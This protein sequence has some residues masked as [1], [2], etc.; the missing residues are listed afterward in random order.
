[1]LAHTLGAIL[2]QSWAHNL[3]AISAQF[4][5][6]LLALSW[7]NLGGGR[8]G[9]ASHLEVSRGLAGDY[10]GIA[11]RPAIITPILSPITRRRNRRLGAELGFWAD[12]SNSA[13]QTNP[14][15]HLLFRR[16]RPTADSHRYAASARRSSSVADGGRRVERRNAIHKT[17]LRH[18]WLAV[19]AQVAPYS[20][21][22]G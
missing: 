6:V 20:P 3:G 21:Q 9:Y 22:R 5:R 7:R 11:R 1:M 4:Q 14:R 10:R 17:R 8:I 16:A 13:P 19:S 2:A 18:M 12:Y 15:H